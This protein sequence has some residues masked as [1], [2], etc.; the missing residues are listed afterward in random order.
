MK[1]LEMGISLYS[2]PTGE[3][4]GGFIYRGLLSDGIGL[5]KRSIFLYGS[6]VRGT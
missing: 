2:D 6:F 4:V 1:A 5:W 3:P